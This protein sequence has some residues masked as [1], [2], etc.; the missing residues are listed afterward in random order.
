MLCSGG[1][2]APPMVYCDIREC[3][4]R[5]GARRHDR[6]R[7]SP[8]RPWQEPVFQMTHPRGHYLSE[9]RDGGVA[10]AVR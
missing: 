9:R 2:T 1:A 4:G 3:L 7:P 8:R 10:H 6:R 5:N